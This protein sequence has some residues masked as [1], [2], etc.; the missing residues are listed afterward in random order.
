[1]SLTAEK[2]KKLDFPLYCITAQNLSNGRS[3]CEVVRAMLEGGAKIIQYREKYAEI[4]VR[5]NE[6]IVIKEMCQKAGCTFIINDNIDI[7]MLV[8]PDGVHIG[9]DDLPIA[10]VRKL[11]G[12]D[13]IIGLS[14]HSPE[15]A[16]QAV[17][18]GA[19]YIGVGPLF[20]TKTKDHVCAPVG[21]EYL[22][23]VVKNIDLPY[24]AIGGIKE[25]NMHLPL[26]TGA[27]CICLVSDITG[28][29]DISA[30]VRRLISKI[31]EQQ[32]RCP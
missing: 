7:A 30:K 20:P 9:Q 2:R 17:K 4:R 23:Y 19:D 12:S 29:D 22:E 28:A 1:M 14:T 27:K 31:E 25:H 18:D 3:N 16:E 11:V 32:G 8:R 13:M 15:Q 21:L 5:Y 24:T 26:Q 6:C 10:E